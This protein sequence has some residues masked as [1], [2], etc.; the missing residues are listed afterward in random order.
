[1]PTRTDGRIRP[2]V[3][4]LGLTPF[5][6]IAAVGAYLLMPDTQGPARRP[7]ASSPDPAEPRAPV[8]S[9][10]APPPAP[11]PVVL[12]SAVAALPSAA[13]SGSTSADERRAIDALMARP[14]GSDQWSDEQKNAYRAQLAHELRS[15]ERNLEW[16]VAAARR[17][18]DKAREQSETETLDYVRRLR[19]VLET[20][21]ATPSGAA[22]PADAGSAGD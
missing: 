21:V 10:S 5:V 20:P 14:P 3:W 1:M 18:G 19:E 4:L 9:E 11:L 2:I 6:A 22:S 17:S 13:P 16:E 12:P 7:T 8:A 15:R